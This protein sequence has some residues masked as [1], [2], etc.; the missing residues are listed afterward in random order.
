MDLFKS[1]LATYFVS[2]REE[3]KNRVMKWSSLLDYAKNMFQSAKEFDQ[4]Y[5]DM[6]DYV[7][8]KLFN[9]EECYLA[10]EK[11]S[12]VLNDSLKK[13]RMAIRKRF[14]SA[15][16]K[17]SG[18]RRKLFLDSP[19][20]LTGNV[21]IDLVENYSACD[22]DDEFSCAVINITPHSRVDQLDPESPGKNKQIVHSQC[23][24]LE[25]LIGNVLTP[26]LD[27]VEE[28]DEEFD[29]T[30]DEDY[31]PIESQKRKEFNEK[32]SS[33]SSENGSDESSSD[34]DSGNDDS[35]NARGKKTKKKKASAEAELILLS[36]QRIDES[37]TSGSSIIVK[38][39]KF[40]INLLSDYDPYVKCGF[41][42]M[43]EMKV[44]NQYSRDRV[45]KS[46]I[47]IP[48]K[49]QGPGI[50][51]IYDSILKFRLLEFLYRPQGIEPYTALRV[52]ILENVNALNNGGITVTEAT[53]YLPEKHE[54]YVKDKVNEILL[55]MAEIAEYSLQELKK[56]GFEV[57]GLK[58]T[59]PSKTRFLTQRYK[60]DS[61][62]WWTEHDL[63][64]YEEGIES[65]GSFGTEGGGSLPL[66]C[67]GVANL[68]LWLNNIHAGFL[69]F[70]EF[71]ILDEQTF[72]N[73]LWVGIGFAEEAILMVKQF[74]YFNKTRNHKVCLRIYGV[75]LH[76][77]V[78]DIAVDIIRR[79]ECSNNILV[80]IE[81]V[82]YINDEFCAKYFPE[83][84]DIVYT[85]GAFH[86]LVNFK[87]ISLAVELKAVLLCSHG[88]A[89]TI[90]N[91]YCEYNISKVHRPMLCVHAGLYR[92]ETDGEGES[93][94]IYICKYPH[95]HLT[96]RNIYEYAVVNAYS[97]SSKNIKAETWFVKMIEKFRDMS[98][99]VGTM[100]T[101]YRVFVTTGA[102]SD[103]LNHFDIEA[104]DVVEIV[105]L[106]QQTNQRSISKGIN[107]LAEKYALKIDYIVKTE[108]RIFLS[109]RFDGDETPTTF[110][111]NLL[112]SY[113]QE[114]AEAD[115]KD[116]NQ[117]VNHIMQFL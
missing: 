83:R 115:Y 101:T 69:G 7:R 39:L 18:I 57:E 107:D 102:Y 112:S 82:L 43:D 75:E 40:Y 36:S 116:T 84:I 60:A 96:S 85:S 71:T 55:I 38:P 117:I 16:I 87:L 62:M 58:N 46:T 19:T 91:L 28:E 27:A 31:R 103:F 2:E 54:L 35:D 90:I 26:Q 73:I 30:N 61:Y 25:A 109:I 105:K 80:L 67:N 74:D 93:R 100:M 51:L 81:N 8:S 95:N 15:K 32:Q 13:K 106:H 23:D 37:L 24:H 79:H 11:H 4:G 3:H 21:E 49:H 88:T 99:G 41:S 9:S 22:S 29:D 65:G 66:N 12:F 50:N 52:Q 72:I 94:K 34:A 10:F 76:K 44:T 77:E 86:E 108:L 47:F 98:K 104:D 63:S 5:D 6:C 114:V 59:K 113:F 1:N 92:S 53:E 70:E 110:I 33:S 56:K 89:K 78:A 48:L 111:Y 14:N 64:V 17:I 68:G 97:C 20:D 45:C 42:S